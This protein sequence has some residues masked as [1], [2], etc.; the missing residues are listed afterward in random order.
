MSRPIDEPW[1]NVPDMRPA[2]AGAGVAGA[3]DWDAIID[4]DDDDGAPGED[5]ADVGE[6]ADHDEGPDAD[7][8]A[9]PSG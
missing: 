3:T 2:A 6:D 8:R 7:D 4:A 5:D 1:A 9:R